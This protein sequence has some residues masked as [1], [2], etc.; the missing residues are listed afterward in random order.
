M[1]NFEFSS[2]GI[3]HDGLTVHDVLQIL[4]MR[5]FTEKKKKITDNFQ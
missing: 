4:E 1:T 2:C 3:S 5:D